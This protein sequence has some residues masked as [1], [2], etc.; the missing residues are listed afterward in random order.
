LLAPYFSFLKCLHY[1]TDGYFSLILSCVWWVLR[2]GRRN[3]S[4][5][6]ALDTS[7]PIR[8]S[9]RVNIAKHPNSSLNCGKP[10]KPW[11]HRLPTGQKPAK[12]YLDWQTLENDIFQPSSTKKAWLATHDMGH[13]AKCTSCMA[14]VQSVPRACMGRAASPKQASVAGG[15]AVAAP[16]HHSTLE[17]DPRWVA[18]TRVSKELFFSCTRQFLSFFS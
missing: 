17:E 8:T 7:G 6:I 12:I 14:I 13:R 2:F 11:K 1:R 5:R 4:I 3:N 9:N 16:I 18:H 15:L 10:E